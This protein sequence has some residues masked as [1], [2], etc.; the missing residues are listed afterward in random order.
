MTEH[1][2]YIGLGS[3]LGDRHGHLQQALSRLE[4]HPSIT[5]VEVSSLYETVP[6]GLVDQSAFLNGVAEI[7]T[8]VSCRQLFELLQTIE[9]ELEMQRNERWG[10]RTIDLD[11]LLYD[12]I[13]V[14]EPGLTIPH[15]QMHLR[16]FVLKGL[17]ELV[18]DVLHPV[19]G[20]TMRELAGRLNG[21]DYWLDSEKPQLISIAG[22]IG[23][24]KTTLATGLAERLEAKLISEK[25]DANPFLAD[26]YAGKTEL[27]LDSELFFLSSSASQ[28]RKDRMK[29]GRVYVND[30][31][32]EKAH[33]YAS[34]WLEPAD[35]AK[36]EKHFDS[37][38]EGVTSPILVIYLNDSVEHCLQRIHQR[39]RPYEQQIE[40]AFLEHLARGYDALYTDYTVSPV[41]RLG[42]DECRTAEQVDRIAEEVK[43]YI[44][45]SQE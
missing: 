9:Q 41:I 12:D 11:L 15:P 16:S 23:V 7:K 4:V 31:V 13:V 25:Y 35:L 45:K 27:A 36:Y 43:Y 28:L 24:G 10:P 17:C 37:M 18:P 8:T 19:L 34:G 1:T 20:W 2:A 5:L 21:G 33:I 26:V 29:A 38:C 3:N 40:P 44:A 14:N 42:S 32:F 6:L 30:Y 39:N 22:N